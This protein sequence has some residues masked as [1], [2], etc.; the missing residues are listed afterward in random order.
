MNKEG[1]MNV[2]MGVASFGPFLWHTTKAIMCEFLYSQTTDNDD[3]VRNLDG[4]HTVFDQDPKLRRDIR[5][6][7]FN[8]TLYPSAVGT[9]HGCAGAAIVVN[10]LMQELEPAGTR[11]LAKAELYKIRHS[12]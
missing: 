7:S 3:L 11:Y 9:N 12:I 4:M 6:V 8:E 5:L 2:I 1:F 10:S